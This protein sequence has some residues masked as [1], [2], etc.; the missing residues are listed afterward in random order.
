MDD[1]GTIERRGDQADL[2]YERRYPRPIESVWAAL[3]DPARLEDWLGRARVE[4]R[5]GGCYELF[6]DRA[7]PM[8]GRIRTWDPPRLLEYSWNAD[9]GG[10]PESVVRCE[11]TPDGDGTRLIFRHRGLGFPWVGLVS[12]GWHTHFERLDGL[13]AGKVRPLDMARWR[14]LQGSYLDRYKFEG[15]MLDPPP[16]HG[17]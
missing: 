12:P 15:V 14:A 7:K 4:P 11:L 3:T 2:C 9:H 10:G 13:L 1:L 5:V 16:G 6:V 17:G 8:Q